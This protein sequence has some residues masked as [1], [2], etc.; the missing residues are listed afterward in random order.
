MIIQ[1][2]KITARAILAY[3]EGRRP[4][5]IYQVHRWFARRFG[6]VFRALLTRARKFP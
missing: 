1:R 6:S 2:E 5:P 4:R 3:R